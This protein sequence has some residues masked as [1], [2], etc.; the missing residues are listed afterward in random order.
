MKS[1]STCESASPSGS[2]SSELRRSRWAA[3]T[4]QTRKSVAKKNKRKKSPAGTMRLHINKVNDGKGSARAP[5]CS[6]LDPTGDLD[7]RV[8]KWC[9]SQGYRTKAG[10]LTKCRTRCRGC[11]S[12]DGKPA[13][14][15]LCLEC[16]KPYHDWLFTKQT[17]APTAQQDDDDY[18]GQQQQGLRRSPRKHP[19]TQ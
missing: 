14:V 19:R 2:A 13:P 8:C 7:K 3:T 9:Y 11:Q 6:G 17:Q 18:A 12:A 10:H 1:A 15:N 5:R 16:M 4:N